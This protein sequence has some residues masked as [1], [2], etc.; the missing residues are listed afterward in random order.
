MK[1][2]VLLIGVIILLSS[3]NNQDHIITNQGVAGIQLGKAYDQD[4][5]TSDFDITFDDQNL[6]K[7]IIISNANYITIDGFGVGTSFD[8]MMTKYDFLTINEDFNAS[9]GKTPIIKLGKTIV[10]DK[11]IFLDSTEDGIVDHI[12]LNDF[13]H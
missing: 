1:K 4:Y 11:I 3:C 9:K 6:V 7:T 12:I 13:D 8:E 2:I 10:H 5:D